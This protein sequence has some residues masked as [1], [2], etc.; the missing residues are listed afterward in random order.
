MSAYVSPDLVPHFAGSGR[1]TLQAERYLDTVKFSKHEF[2]SHRGY[3]Q[4]KCLTRL[5]KMIIISYVNRIDS[6]K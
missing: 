3:S 5:H 4:E 1:G 6:Q 2:K